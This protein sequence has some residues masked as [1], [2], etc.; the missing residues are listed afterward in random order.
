[1][2][3][4]KK[5]FIVMAL[6]LSS[7]SQAQSNFA[8]EL[9]GGLIG[10]GLSAVLCRELGASRDLQIACSIGGAVLGSRVAR[11]MSAEDAHAYQD[12]QREAWDGEIGRDYRWE[13]RRY[14]SRTDI[15]GRI[16]PMGRGYHRQTRE[17]C[18]TFRT[19]TYRGTYAY[20]EEKTSIVCRKSN[21]SFYNLQQTDVYV[22][23]RL[24]ESERRESSGRVTPPRDRRDRDYGRDDSWDRDYDRDRGGR[25]NDG[26]ERDRRDSDRRDRRNPPRYDDRG[27]RRRPVPQPSVMCDGWRLNHLA[28]G[29]QAFDSRGYEITFRGFNPNSKTVIVYDANGRP[30]TI[31]MHEIGVPGCHY[32]WR[33]GDYVST[34]KGDGRV[35]GVYQN[36]DVLVEVDR[37]AERVRNNEIYR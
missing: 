22:N 5:R 27:H 23:G 26:W 34:A 3:S 1:M 32:G 11:E 2:K 8:N 19:I 33:T 25:D 31:G 9:L 35:L 30:R 15:H 4:I 28:V 17:E 21:G 24:V 16:R 18:R 29:S 13:G 14:G 10:G 7:A 6:A 20:E 36:G 12:S 37:F